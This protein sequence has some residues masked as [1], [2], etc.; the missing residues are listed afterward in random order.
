MESKLTLDDRLS[1]EDRTSHAQV[2][3][4]VAK[5]SA[6]DVLNQQWQR[7]RDSLRRRMTSAELKE[8][9]ICTQSDLH[10]VVGRLTHEK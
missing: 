3:C 4:S 5:A 1:M 2:E 6:K 8:D 10:M 7:A 9:T